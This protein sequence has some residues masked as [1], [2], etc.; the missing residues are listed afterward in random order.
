MAAFSPRRKSGLHVLGTVSVLLLMA[1]GSSSGPQGKTYTGTLQ[2]AQFTSFTG[3]NANFGPEGQAGCIPAANLINADGGVLGH[4]VNCLAVDSRGDPADAVPAANQVAAA[5]PNLVAIL[6]PTSDEADATIP[7]F[8]RSKITM[9]ATAGSARYDKSIYKYLWRNTPADDVNGYALAIWAKQKGYTRA[10]AIFGGDVSSQGSKPTAIAGFEKLGGTI[11]STIDLALDQSSYRSEVEQ[12]LAKNPQV[13]FTEADPQTDATFFQELLQSHGS[14]LPIIGTQPTQDQA[15]LDAVSHAVGKNNLAAAYTSVAPFADPSGPAYALFDSAL[16]NAGAAVPDYQQW[17]TDPYAM[18]A[19]DAVNIIALAM[20]VAN[21]NDPAI[22]ND[23]IL[24]VTTKSS[25]A[26]VVN[27]F[28]DG[29]AALA[30]GKTI[31]YVGNGGELAFDQWHNSPG[32]FG[33]YTYTP[34]DPKNQTTLVGNVTSAQIAQ[35][36]S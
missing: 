13:I 9:F 29:K 12:V 32:Q 25:G 18:T 5:Q 3:P 6:G 15:W 21:S 35:V 14:L 28:K 1:C 33:V 19:Y 23:D 20:I 27:N 7:I 16:K 24:K 31:E 22:Y 2:I 11:T 17:E 36:K 34:T 10:A 8:N 26:T 4:Q 30:A